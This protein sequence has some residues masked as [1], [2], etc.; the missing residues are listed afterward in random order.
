MDATATTIR[1]ATPADVPTLAGTL[2]RAYFDDPVAVWA[3][4]SDALR[5]RMLEGQYRTRLRQ[6]LAQQE[7]WTTP[8]CSSVALWAAP[9]QWQTTFRQDAAQARHLL[10]PAILVRL[11]LLAFGL[12]SLHGRHPHTPP[13]WY[14][15]LLGT[16]P[17][18]QGHGLGSAVLAPVLERCD[19]DGVGA[20][21]ESSK[22]RNIDFYARHG[23]RTT[24]ELRLPR[25]PKM[26]FMW[27][28]PHSGR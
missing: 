19:S 10:H 18:L 20:Y 4:A 12:R 7:V 1:R 23:F 24:G 26:W 21:L 25:G 28:E 3:C 6:M 17:E 22:E 8:E 5:P 15:S 14:L 16:E 2:V 27:R 11:P 13:H 9:G